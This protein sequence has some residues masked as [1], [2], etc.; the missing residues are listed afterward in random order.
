MRIHDLSVIVAYLI[1]ITWFGARFR[2]SQQT[3]KDYFLGGRNTPWWAIGFSI[4]SAETST[5]TVI[6]TPGISFRGDFAIAGDGGGGSGVRNLDC[7][8]DCA[9][10]GGTGFDID[11]C[12]ADAFLYI[13]GRDDGCDLDRRGANVSLRVGRA[14]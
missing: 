14:D 6:G 12:R 10:D 8:L 4:V 2:D 13:R 1:G 5:L 11:D 7:D 3:L 9:G